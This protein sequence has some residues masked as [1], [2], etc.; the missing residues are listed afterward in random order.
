MSP[1]SEQR[2]EAL[3]CALA[4]HY[5]IRGINLRT[6]CERFDWHHIGVINESQVTLIPLHIPL[7]IDK[8]SGYV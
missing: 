3:L 5:Q 1:N 8:L 6:E 7:D 2:L 4:K